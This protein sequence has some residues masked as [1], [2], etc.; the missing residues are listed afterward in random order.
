M[1]ASY[2]THAARSPSDSLLIS[3][4]R[5]G[6]K[7]DLHAYDP[8]VHRWEANPILDMVGRPRAV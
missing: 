3:S 7:G 4:A 1:N 6:R 8:D 5:F 2:I